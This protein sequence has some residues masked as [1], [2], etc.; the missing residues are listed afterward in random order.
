MPGVFYIHPGK[1]FMLL[2]TEIIQEI[3]T[4]VH[5]SW[6]HHRFMFIHM[7][8]GMILIL[9][10]PG[11]VL[12]ATVE[13]ITDQVQKN[14]EKIDDFKTRFVQEMTIKTL[15]KTEREEGVVYFKNPKRMLW[16]YTKP[17]AKKLIINPKQA[18]LYI[19]EDHIVYLQSAE[20]IFKSRVLIKFLTGIGKISDD[21]EIT[22]SQPDSVDGNGNYLLTLA[23]KDYD[24]GVKQLF[25]TI[26]KESYQIIKCRF[27]DDYGNVT[28]IAF[29]DMEIN[30]KIPDH[31]FTFKPPA[32]VE[33][34]KTP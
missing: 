15:K 17:K 24:T 28:Q 9:A 29:R 26:D 6:R 32:G 3:M 23:P 14:Y 1:I 11:S 12:S 21:F 27:A 22:F 5:T 13:E 30:K 33:I 8:I 16:D 18:W 25:L 7:L 4:Y 10:A 19:P 20:S 31:F 2:L 34:F